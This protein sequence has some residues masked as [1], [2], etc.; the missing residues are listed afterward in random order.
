MSWKLYF[1]TALENLLTNGFQII[2]IILLI[3]VALKFV[4]IA[5]QKIM[6]FI[7]NSTDDTEYEK[8]ICTLKNIIKSTLDIVIIAIGLMMIIEKLGINIGPIIAAA[9][10]VGL[11]VGFGSQRFVEDIISGLIIIITDQIRVGD[12]VQIGDKN[13]L[14]EKV[15][16]KMVVLRDLSGNVHFIRNGKID[17]VTNMT[18]EY[19]Y[20]LMDIGISCKEN[21]EKVIETIKDANKKIINEN[22]I[23]PVE[24]LGLDKFENSAIVIKAR[25]KTKPVKQWE[26][27]REFNLKLKQK[28]DESGIEVIFLRST[29]N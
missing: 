24:I 11:A 27:G 4:K 25:I 13:G 23:E 3:V 16:L 26:V 12:Y 8:K 17:I 19:S 9:G 22:I 14:V 2:L 21:I 29:L 15:D 10:V 18:K 20:Y 6:N 7:V 28:F 5:T 1:K